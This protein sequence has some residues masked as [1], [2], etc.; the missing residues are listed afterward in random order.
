MVVAPS[1]GPTSSSATRIYAQTPAY[2]GMSVLNTLHMNILV[3]QSSIAEEDHRKSYVWRTLISP[4]WK[5][6]S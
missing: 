1:P 4:Q 6:P 5:A 3:I 2:H